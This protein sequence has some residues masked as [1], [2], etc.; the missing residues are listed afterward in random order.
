MLLSGLHVTTPGGNAQSTCIGAVRANATELFAAAIDEKGII[1]GWEE[2]SDLIIPIAYIRW[3][4]AVL[5]KLQR[6]ESF[7]EEAM[8][9]CKEF[10]LNLFPLVSRHMADEEKDRIKNLSLI[11]V[12]LGGFG[13]QGNVGHQSDRMP[14]RSRM[15]RRRSIWKLN[16]NNLNR[17]R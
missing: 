16:S 11:P 5:N 1:D 8:D 15:V 9:A 7:S 13:Y 14:N 2:I 17:K 10:L 12:Y 3:I 4:M 6:G